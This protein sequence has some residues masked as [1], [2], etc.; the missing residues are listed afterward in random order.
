MIRDLEEVEFELSLEK[1]RGFQDMEMA[2]EEILQG[3]RK[4]KARNS[5]WVRLTSE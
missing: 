2:V 4:D 5:K 1:W 3:V